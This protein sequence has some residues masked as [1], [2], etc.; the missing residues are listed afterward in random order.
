MKIPFSPQKIIYGMKP[1]GY[2][3]WFH[4]PT[5]AERQSLLDLCTTIWICTHNTRNTSG[6]TTGSFANVKVA[7]LLPYTWYRSFQTWIAGPGAWNYWAAWAPISS[8]GAMKAIAYWYRFFIRDNG[9]AYCTPESTQA[10]FSTTYWLPIRLFADTSVVP[11]STRTTIMTGA[12]LNEN[13]NIIT[14]TD[15]QTYIT[16]AD[17][18][19]GAKERRYPSREVTDANSWYLFQRGNMHPF[20]RSGAID[21]AYGVVVENP[22][23]PY[24][25]DKF[26]IKETVSTYTYRSRSEDIKD[27]FSVNSI[28]PGFIK[29]TPVKKV[30]VGT[31]TIWEPKAEWL[32]FIAQENNCTVGLT[33]TWQPIAVTLKTSTDWITRQDY[34]IGTTLTLSNIWDKV[35]FKNADGFSTIT[36]FSTSTSDYYYF[37]T[38]WLLSVRWD[39]TYLLSPWWNVTTIWNYCFFKLFMDTTITTC[40]ELP[41]TGLGTNCYQCIF[42]RCTNLDDVPELPATVGKTGCYMQMFDWCTSLTKAPKIN[43]TSGPSGTSGNVYSYMF[44]GC[45]NLVQLPALPATWTRRCTYMFQDCSKIKASQTQTWDYTQEYTIGATST[46]MFSGTWWTLTWTPSSS[47]VYIHTDNTIV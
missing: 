36:R 15:W 4:L 39:T 18:N 7:L 21:V 24:Y 10:K 42:Q 6:I 43:L 37:V 2:S 38:T 27:L 8:S 31:N 3:T 30:K 25:S 5:Q 12:Y 34:T 26:L 17:R 28:F 11:D 20:P 45:S 16:I 40:P 46:S 44:R 41:S 9:A 14:I 47:P 19:V 22:P 35:Y 29:Q 33:Q 13:D 32:C 1:D 23:I